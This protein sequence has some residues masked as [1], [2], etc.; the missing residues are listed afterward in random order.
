M[1]TTHYPLSAR[2]AAWAVHCLTMSG[3]VWASLATLAAIHEEITWMWVWL[4]VALVVDG[5]DGTLARRT[6]VAEIIP[7]FDGVIVDIVVDY[8]TWTFIPALFM[9][10]Y[11]PMGAGP[12]KAFM[13]ILILSSSMFCYA[14]KNWKST[15]YY[16]V[17]FP[18]A[19]NIVALMFYVL[20]TPTWVN[21]P[22]TIILAILTLVPTHYLH[23]ARV[24]RFRAL[25]I[26]SAG[27]W[28]AASSWLVAVYPDRPL[29]LVAAV[30]ISG[31]W[32]MLVGVLRSIRG[33]DET[34]TA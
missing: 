4:L 14:N 6:R 1:T 19:W 34:A 18:A 20:G 22:V 27:V 16:F 11:L 8:L 32:F 7:W 23:P 13:L 2:A 9:Y 26:A 31:G 25:N 15:D 28:L 33:A 30:V 29:P 21:V 3:L 12:V 24:K 10:L 17:G 5:V